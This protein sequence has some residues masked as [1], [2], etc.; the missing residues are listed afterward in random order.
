MCSTA[1]EAA[2]EP[3][4]TGIVEKSRWQFEFLLQAYPITGHTRGVA[5]HALCA[6]MLPARKGVS[7]SI[8]VLYRPVGWNVLAKVAAAS[9]AAWLRK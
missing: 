8:H 3:G 2:A 5:I 1:A 7:R 6:A 4:A 9:F